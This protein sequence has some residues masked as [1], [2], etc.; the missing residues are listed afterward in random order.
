MR[1]RCRKDMK[2]GA[3]INGQEN[4]IKTTMEGKYCRRPTEEELRGEK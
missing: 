2:R 4:E 3:M 1:W